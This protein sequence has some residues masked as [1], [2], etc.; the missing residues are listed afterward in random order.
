VL[1]ARQLEERLSLGYESRGLE[2]KGPGPRS[3]KRLFAK[4][5]RAAL[6]LGNLRDGGYV[7]IGISDESPDEMQPG[8]SSAD[9]ASWIDYDNVARALAN[10]ADPPLRFD[11]ASLKLS[12]GA[13]VAVIE[14]NE[15]EDIPHLCAKDY[16]GVL[17][18]GALYVRPRKVPETAEVPSAV[19]MREL[20]D[21]ATEKAL[22][23]YVETADRAGLSLRT[24]GETTPSDQEQYRAE[25]ADAWK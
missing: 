8:L 13:E 6:S 9:L 22:R 18:E 17:R 24:E 23:A 14:V 25:E 11:I 12:S 15:F 3:D 4:V 2:L 21:L 19:E 5:T 10:Y 7:V 20:I 16:E 1:D